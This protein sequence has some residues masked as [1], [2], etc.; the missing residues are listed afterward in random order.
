MKGNEYVHTPPQTA[1]ILGS[2]SYPTT[3]TKGTLARSSW[4]ALTI[5]GTKVRRSGVS[6]TAGYSPRRASLVA[7]IYNCPRARAGA[8]WG[9]EKS[10]GTKTG[11]SFVELAGCLGDLRGRGR[12]PAHG[13]HACGVV[14]IEELHHVAVAA[15]GVLAHTRDPRKVV[16]CSSEGASEKPAGAWPQR[17]RRRAGGRCRGAGRR[18]RR[19]RAAAEVA[20]S[21]ETQGIPA[22]GSPSSTAMRAS[23]SRRQAPPESRRCRAAG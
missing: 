5:E 7:C 10:A 16:R 9:R 22:A 11:S 20:D 15:R 4:T 21:G 17:R 2:K 13:V 23:A 19:R 1:P 12:P 3:L 6:T 8:Q 18:S 14:H